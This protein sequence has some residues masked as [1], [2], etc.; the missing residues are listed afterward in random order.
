MTITHDLMNAARPR[1]ARATRQN[2]PSQHSRA[3]RGVAI[4]CDRMP[5]I[6][7][8]QI[9]LPS[10]ASDR[11]AD[12]LVSVLGAHLSFHCACGGSA[13]EELVSGRGTAATKARL[14]D[15]TQALASPQADP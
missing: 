2:K 4:R 1:V 12:L 15:R 7:T 11:I 8:H 10:V 3:G 14:A 6:R 5:M 13:G 9:E